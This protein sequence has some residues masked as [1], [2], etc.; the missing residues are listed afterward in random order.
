MASVP[1]VA[2][3]AAAADPQT[4]GVAVFQACCRFYRRAAIGFRGCVRQWKALS[5]FAMPQSHVAAGNQA[6]VSTLKLAGKQMSR[7]REG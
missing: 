5:F 4:V 3:P 7:L 6:S 2:E 1:T